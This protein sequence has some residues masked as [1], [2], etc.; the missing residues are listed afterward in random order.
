MTTQI[1][2]F[3]NIIMVALV[4]GTIFGIW[5]GYNPIDLS[6]PTYIEQQQN[7]I[8]ALNTI[9]PLLGLITIILTLISAFL[10]KKEKGVFIILLIATVF[11]ILSGLATK[12]GNQPINSIVMT[13]DMNTPPDNW[14]A[15]RDQWWTYH[16]IRT[17]TAF[18]ALCLIV[19]TSM[20]KD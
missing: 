19:W 14:V 15:L 20:K 6:A 9:M 7:S 1:I 13:W 2:R 16:I 5:L 11:L 12:F 8:R 17:S 4:A 18:V 3:L 10:R